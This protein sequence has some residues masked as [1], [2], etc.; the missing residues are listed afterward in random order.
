M[1]EAAKPPC[2]GPQAGRWWSQRRAVARRTEEQR[3]SAGPGGAELGGMRWH[4]R[5]EPDRPAR[6]TTRNGSAR[7]QQLLGGMQRPAARGRRGGRREAHE[8]GAGPRVVPPRTTSAE[9]S[10]DRSPRPR[11]R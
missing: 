11:A 3:E 6:K 9:F 2:K 1:P 5:P 4:P 10:M 7:A 8:D